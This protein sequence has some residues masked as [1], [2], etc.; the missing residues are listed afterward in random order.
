LDILACLVDVPSL[1]R[2]DL[3]LVISNKLFVSLFSGLNLLLISYVNDE[4]VS[5]INKHKDYV[6]KDFIVTKSC[7]RCK[8]QNCKDAFIYSVRQSGLQL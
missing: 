6:K 4:F 1:T 5:S 3:L 2:Q 7:N 8:K